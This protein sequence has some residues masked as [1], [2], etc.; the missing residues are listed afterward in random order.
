MTDRERKLAAVVGVLAAC[1]VAVG[2]YLFVYEP[3]QAAGRQADQVERDIGEQKLQLA[4]IA[5]DRPRLADALRRSLPADVQAAGL[6]YEAAITNLLNQAYVPATGRAVRLKPVSDKPPPLDPAERDPKKQVPAYSAV[7]LEVTLKRVKYATLL[8][9]LYRYHRLNLLH[10]ISRFTVKRVDESGAKKAGTGDADLPDL[11][12]SFTST[13][14]S[15]NGAEGRRSL[16]PVPQATAAAAGGAGFAAVG[17][18]PVAARGLEPLQFVPVLATN[19]R[20]Y[21]KLLVQDIFHGP[22]PPPPPAEPPPPP[23]EET[24]AFIRLTGL[25]RNADGTGSALIEDAASRNEYAIDLGRPGGKLTPLVSKFYYTAKGAK[26]RL[27]DPDSTLDISESSSGT[28]RLFRVI[29]LDDG[30][31]VLA[32]REPK[33]ESGRRGGRDGKA[34]PAAAAGGAAVYVP[35]ER[36]FLWRIGD[37]LTKVRELSAGEARAAIQRATGEP[38]DTVTTSAPAADTGDGS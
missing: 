37:A 19:N 34:P 26:K 15:L 18:S 8:D 38:A 24:A 35:A 25:G 14:I 13:A 2:G 27:D 9:V 30:G 4:Q 10:Q 5:K 31:L 21:A 16:L 33:A 17:Q 6:E 36:V 3:I 23:K 32:S 29:G 28:A 22:P 7:A 11:E 12:V 1:A 20:N